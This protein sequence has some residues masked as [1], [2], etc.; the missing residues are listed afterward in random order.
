[1][2]KNKSSITNGAV[3]KGKKL[4]KKFGLTPLMIW[5]GVSGF[6]IV[7]VATLLIVFWPAGQL[8]NVVNDVLSN[9][10]N[11]ECEFRSNLDGKCVE[12]DQNTLPIVVMID[13]HVDAR[14]PEGIDE[15]SIVFEAIAEGTITRLVAVF[16]MNME[17]TDIGPVRSAR[18]Y[19]VDYA[20]EFGA[21]YAHVGGSDEA[22]S[23]LQRRKSVYDLNEFSNAAYFWRD[24]ARVAPH[25]VMTSSELLK[26][27]IETKEWSTQSSFGSWIFRPE[28]DKED[29]GDMISARIDYRSLVHN[30]TW[31]YD[32]EENV[33]WRSQGG[34]KHKMADGTQLSAK[35]IA[36]VYTE[37][38]P[39]D[40]YGRRRTTTIG[41]GKAVVLQEG[42]AIEAKWQRDNLNDRTR[43]YDN[44]TGNEINFV[45]GQTWI[46]VIPDHFP[47]IEIK[48]SDEE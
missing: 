38:T 16:D 8:D 21:V 14:P 36:I 33:Y 31:V 4:L 32:N 1:M 3:D 35:N 13:N 44:E 40:D 10:N 41:S 46:E 29:R 48:Y 43:F 28:V 11:D 26:R 6:S 9:V 2:V 5:I 27:A 42:Y 18:P 7:M 25:S 12:N 15:A 17:P 47:E 45:P 39:I 22:L 34:L 30:I 19:F 37:S 23:I 24:P 20:T